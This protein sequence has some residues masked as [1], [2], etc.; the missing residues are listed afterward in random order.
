MIFCAIGVDG[1]S[2]APKKQPTML[3]TALPAL[4]LLGIGWYFALS[5]VGGIGGGLLL[6]GWL[7]TKPLFTAIGLLF[8]MLVAFWGAYKLLMQVLSDR[9]REENGDV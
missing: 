5:I 7:G 4:G 8:G 2:G 9:N 1:D 3:S 6:D